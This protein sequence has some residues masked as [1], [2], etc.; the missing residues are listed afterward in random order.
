MRDDFSLWPLDPKT[1]RKI[2]KAAIRYAA[3]SPLQATQSP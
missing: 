2:M 1:D 3:K